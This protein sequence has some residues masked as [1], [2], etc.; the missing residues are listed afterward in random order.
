MFSKITTLFLFISCLLLA[1]EQEVPTPFNIKTVTFVQG[2]NNAIP[3]FRLGDAFEL[4]FD[5]LYGNEADYYYTIE[6]YNYDWTPSSLLKNEYIN[7]LD[8]QRIQNYSNSLNCFQNYSHYTLSF[9]NKYNQIIKSG[10]YMVKI[11]DDE[12]H[13]IFS[14]KLIIYE[15]DLMIGITIRRSRDME[16]IQQKQNVEFF[17]DYKDRVLQN[18]L[19]NIKVSIFQNGKFQ[20][21]IHN[22]KPQYTIGT[23]LIYRYNKETQ[24]WG[25]NEFWNFENKNIRGASN[26]VFKVT[27]GD[28]YNTYLYVNEARKNKIYTYFPDINGNFLVTNFNITNPN[29]ESD[30]AWV[31]FTL[32]CK[33]NPLEKNIYI[34]GM[35]NNYAISDENKMDY[36][37]TTNRFEKALLI[38]QGFTNYQYVLTDLNGKIDE[39]NAIDGNFYQTE[40]NYTILVYYKGPADRYDRVVGIANATSLDIKN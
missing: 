38:K 25:G 34:N 18:P 5:D 24:F 17:I 4:Q 23:Q 26:T 22:I 29:V 1:Q 31:Y 3:F 16:T 39:K 11:Y 36:N 2:G 14:R 35:F 8:N 40:N 28:I 20:N 13:L 6:H 15:D 12:Q 33:E 19:Q 27:T 30:Y 9:P 10:N 21:A 7:G 37:S 32:D